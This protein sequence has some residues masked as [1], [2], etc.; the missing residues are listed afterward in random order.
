MKSESE[1]EDY[2]KNKKTKLAKGRKRHKVR[3]KKYISTSEDNEDDIPIS[4]L[5]NDD[6]DDDVENRD[7]CAVCHEFGRGR[8]I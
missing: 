7:T 3:S 2:L 4:Q 8:E 6:E 5:C 1:D